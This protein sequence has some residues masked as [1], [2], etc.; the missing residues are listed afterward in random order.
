MNAAIKKALC[1]EAGSDRQWLSKVQ[2]WWYH[3][4]HFHVRLICPSGNPEC[5]PQPARPPGDG[6]GK[7]LDYWFSDKVLHP[8][9]TEPKH[10]PKAL[11]LADLPPAC[12]TVLD[13]PAN[14]KAAER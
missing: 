8:K 14:P 6:C 13:A 7:E 12:K 10:P 9:I 11:T 4:Y 5:K 3:D 2:P 1:R